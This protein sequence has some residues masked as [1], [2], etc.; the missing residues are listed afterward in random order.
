MF[1][2]ID[3]KKVEV[4]NDEYRMYEVLCSNHEPHGKDIFKNLF[5]VDEDGI[6]IYLIPPTK[7]FSLDAVLFL[8]NLMIHQ[9]LRRV[10]KEHEEAM[11]EVRELLSELKNIKPQ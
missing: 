2:I 5:E 1:K 11:K 4:T 3:N 8:Q 10:Y 7:N 6:I 9:H